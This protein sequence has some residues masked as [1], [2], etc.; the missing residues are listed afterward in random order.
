MV[1]A[2]R[3]AALLGILLVN[4]L[5]FSGPYFGEVLPLSFWHAPV[6]R[7]TEWGVL[8]LAEGAFYSSFSLLFGLG[9]ALQ[10][11]RGERRGE[12]ALPRYRRRLLWLLVIGLAHLLLIWFGDILSHYALIGLLLTLFAAAAPRGLLRAS[13]ALLLLASLF[14]LLAGPG[15][16][17]FRAETD[18][19]ELIRLYRDGGPGEI[20]AHR[21]E[22][23]F[24]AL[25]ATPFL[26][27]GL[28]WL[29]L[30]GF[31]AGKIGV[32]DDPD[33]HSG[34][35]RRTR[36]LALPVALVCKGLYG[37]LLLT[38]PEN[39]FS[40][41]LSTGL[42]GPALGLVY[43][44]SLALL[45][46]DPGLLA[47][48]RPLAAV[49]RMALSNYLA[50]SVV[51]TLLFYGYGFGLYGSLGP[52]TTIWF[53]FGLYALQ[54]ALSSWWLARFRFGPAEWLWRSLSYGRVQPWRQ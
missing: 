26:A 12:S 11:R 33:T 32:F 7:W 38:R 28:L 52:A 9:F 1:D 45:L 15:Q 51:F 22:R 40:F 24:D 37:W 43:T 29:F 54:L 4:M 34:L 50:H 20:L 5:A 23:G 31:A 16:A 30:L 47:L 10:L 42:G 8:V 27:P 14:Y 35:L 39:P 6:D 25:L 13:L 48:L 49:G 21:L 17:Q 53:A 19:A 2:L 46:R 3:G 44:T 18:P 36:A 41:L